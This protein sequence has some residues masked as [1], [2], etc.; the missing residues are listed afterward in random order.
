VIL[1]PGKSKMATRRLF[2]LQKHLIPV[3]RVVENISFT[4][5]TEVQHDEKIVWLTT[6]NMSEIEKLTIFMNNKKYLRKHYPDYS[7]KETHYT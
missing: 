5:N 6:E 1:F 7:F 3:P 4:M 2:T